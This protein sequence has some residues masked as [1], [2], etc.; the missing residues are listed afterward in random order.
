L[1]RGRFD[2][3]GGRYR[4]RYRTNVVWFDLIDGQFSTLSR[5]FLANTS[6]N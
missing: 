3:R 6:I 4:S 2:G 1:L 5:Q